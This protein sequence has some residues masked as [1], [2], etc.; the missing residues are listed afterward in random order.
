MMGLRVPLYYDYYPPRSPS[1]HL[2]SN[3]RYINH[4]FHV[5]YHVSLQRVIN[6]LCLDVFEVME[7]NET[8][9][10]LLKLPLDR[11]LLFLF[12]P[13]LADLN[14]ISKNHHILIRRLSHQR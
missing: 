8:L 3:Q 1:T 11:I 7:M 12:I 9:I 5:L 14:Q 13:K 10:Y 2:G 6:H 4:S